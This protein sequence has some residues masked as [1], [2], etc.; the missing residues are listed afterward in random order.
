MWAATGRQASRTI[1]SLQGRGRAAE[2][3][4]HRAHV[5]FI[6]LR[7]W[8]TVG[9]WAAALVEL[10]GP[11]LGVSEWV[12]AARAG[13][14]VERGPEPA[15]PGVTSASRFC[16]GGGVSMSSSVRR[17]GYTDTTHGCFQVHCDM[18]SLLLPGIPGSKT[19]RCEQSL[20]LKASICSVTSWSNQT[21]HPAGS[22]PGSLQGKGRKSHA[23]WP[24]PT[25]MPTEGRAPGRGRV[26]GRARFHSPSRLFSFPGGLQPPPGDRVAAPLGLTSIRNGR[27]AI[28]PGG[29]PL[30]KSLEF[31]CASSSSVGWC[32]P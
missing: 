23:P 21:W 3:R 19:G 16:S 25:R 29:S 22:G 7:I 12:S 10:G 26:R 20:S 15:S 17:A 5:C 8:Q 24:T 30:W 31:P 32:W 13:G 18:A 14:P 4:G 1:S 2:L 6:F 27:K 28:R 9:S 11:A